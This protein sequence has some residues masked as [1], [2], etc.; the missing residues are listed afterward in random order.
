[1]NVFTVD[2][3]RDLRWENLVRHHPRASV[4]HTRGWLETLRR[5]YGYEPVVYACGDGSADLSSGVVVCQVKSWL[6][7]SRVVSLPF[8]DHCDPLVSTAQE[9]EDLASAVIETV[10]SRGCK[11]FENRPRAGAIVPR[12]GG[13]MAAG[14]T[15]FLDT[16]DIR[17]DVTALFQSFAR[18]AVQQPIKRAER[19]GLECRAGRSKELL[20][21]FYSLLVRTRRRHRVPPQ[22]LKWFENL[23]DCLGDNVTI[24]VAAKGES[25]IAAIL[26]LTFERQAY[27]KY[28]C[29]DER[30]HNLGGIQFLL[31]QTILAEK[32]RGA[33]VL[34][35]G[36]SDVGHES[37]L[38]FKERWGSSRSLL[39]YYRYPPIAYRTSR[40]WLDDALGLAFAQLPDSMIISAGKLL[41][42]HV[43]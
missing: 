10:R 3:L 42:P 9:W 37:L 26:V 21:Q 14:Q 27:Y 18:T 1:M 11:Y 19:E 6:T 15:F 43:G 32:Q 36:R 2:P 28:G 34:D 23:V 38:K 13:E 8:S 29:S 4:F 33:T 16:I 12:E 40:K 20:R 22:P 30:H 17:P 35:M 25:L 7:G 39:T 31:W 41:Y 5:T 24:R